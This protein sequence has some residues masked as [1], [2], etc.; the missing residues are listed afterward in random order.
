MKGKNAEKFSKRKYIALKDCIGVV[1]IC[2]FETE[3]NAAKYTVYLLVFVVFFFI[4]YWK[5][6]YCVQML[7]HSY[8]RIQC[9]FQSF[10]FD[11]YW[12]LLKNTSYAIISFIFPALF[13]FGFVQVSNA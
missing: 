5:N 13:L 10:H 1:H 6:F 9:R 11:A 7:F 3:L 4:P 12:N 8:L 2:L